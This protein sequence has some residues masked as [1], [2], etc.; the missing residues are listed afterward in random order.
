MRG[1]AFLTRMF[2]FLVSTIWRPELF[3]P[4][5]FVASTFQRC[6]ILPAKN[7][8]LPILNE[9]QAIFSYE[10]FCRK[11]SYKKLTCTYKEDECH[12]SLTF[13]FL[14]FLI[15]SFFLTK[16]HLFR[17]EILRIVHLQGDQK[18]SVLGM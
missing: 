17:L 3:M 5:R 1:T 11:F 2:K 14:C 8:N 12:T 18:L 4:R 9:R 7:K 6:N 10:L 16:W 15:A 13:K